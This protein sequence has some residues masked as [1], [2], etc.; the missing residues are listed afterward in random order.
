MKSNRK[1][2]QE[3]VGFVTKELSCDWFTIVLKEQEI[4]N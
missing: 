3:F 1:C 2:V 4:L